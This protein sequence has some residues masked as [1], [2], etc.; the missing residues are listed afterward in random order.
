MG[1]ALV[2][3]KVL[4]VDI[5]YYLNLILILGVGFSLF[6]ETEKGRKTRSVFHVSASI[7]ILLTIGLLILHVTG[8][9]DIKLPLFILLGAVCVLLLIV[10]IKNKRDHID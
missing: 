4:P 8:I 7:I 1:S 9:A 3:W 6:T 10:V 5:W 2:F